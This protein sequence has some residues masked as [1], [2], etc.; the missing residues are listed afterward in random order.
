MPVTIVDKVETNIAKEDI[1]ELVFIALR[2][3]FPAHQPCSCSLYCGSFNY[4][5][6]LPSIIDVSEGNITRIHFGILAPTPPDTRSWFS[7]VFEG[8]LRPEII[9]AV[10]LLFEKVTAFVKDI[11]ID[12][13]DSQFKT[14][15]IN[16]AD[17][18]SNGELRI[19]NS[20]KVTITI[21]TNI[22]LV[23]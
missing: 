5:T 10:D 8:P 15:F 3:H 18:F 23:L 6:G 4:S 21:E 12:V 1:V 19:Y 22:P 17:E 2:K 11:K 14:T 7:K 16:F 9:G 20:E 13:F